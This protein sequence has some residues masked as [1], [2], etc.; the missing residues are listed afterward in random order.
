MEFRFLEPS[1]GGGGGGAKI[2][3]RREFEISRVKSC[4]SKANPMKRALG[5]SR[6]FAKLRVREI[7]ISLQHFML[8]SQSHSHY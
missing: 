1:I 6:V 3:S 2:E 4:D 8:S 7:G 5:S